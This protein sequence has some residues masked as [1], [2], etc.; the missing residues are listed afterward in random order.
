[1]QFAK[2]TSLDGL[3]TSSHCIGGSNTCT[4][5]CYNSL[6]IC[7][8]IQKSDCKHSWDGCPSK[9]SLVAVD[10]S[11]IRHSWSVFHISTPPANQFKIWF[12]MCRLSDRYCT[13]HMDPDALLL[14]TTT[15]ISSGCMCSLGFLYK[16]HDSLSFN[17][18]LSNLGDRISYDEELQIVQ[19]SLCSSYMHGN[20]SYK[21][22]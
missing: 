7:T 21:S 18:V 5:N 19:D 11:Y 3:F 16:V 20:S 10:W 6:W 14:P 9:L 1:M 15:C 22:S 8:A 17:N 2:C 4:G 12:W 13:N